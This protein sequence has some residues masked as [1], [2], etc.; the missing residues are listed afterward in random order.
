M[1]D[2]T[3]NS[4]ST[5]GTLGASSHSKHERQIDDYYA[6]DPSAVDP[7]IPF[8]PDTDVIWECACGEG[9]LSKRLLDLGFVVRSTDLVNRGYGEP[10]INFLKTTKEDYQGQIILTNPPYKYAQEFVEHAL[11]I[12]NQGNY[13]CMFLKVLFLEGQKRKKLFEEHPPYKML[14]FS[15]RKDCAINGDFKGLEERGGG[16]LAYAWFIWVNGFKGKTTVEWI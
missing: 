14:V 9:H 8:L 12:T 15:K 1:K 5:F 11:K 4:R 16:A 3:G 6:T 2:W 7:L 10:N 13:V